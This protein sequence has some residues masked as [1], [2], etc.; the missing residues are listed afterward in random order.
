M[1]LSL[2]RSYMLTE[3]Y[4]IKTTSKEELADGAKYAKCP[5]CSLMVLVIFDIDDLESIIETKS[6][7]KS[8]TTKNQALKSTN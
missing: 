7:K 2:N 1:H 3:N 6:A 4:I 5:S 8:E